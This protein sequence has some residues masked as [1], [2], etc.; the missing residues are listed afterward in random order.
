MSVEF[1][2]LTFPL[3][4]FHEIILLCFY[5]TLTISGLISFSILDS[6]DYKEV[7]NEYIVLGAKIIRRGQWI[8]DEAFRSQLLLVSKMTLSDIPIVI[9]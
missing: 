3:V 1:S 2:S 6:F 9:R 8:M 4:S 5:I 7:S